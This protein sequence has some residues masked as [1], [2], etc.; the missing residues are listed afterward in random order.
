MTDTPLK[1]DRH[2]IAWTLSDGEERLAAQRC[3]GDSARYAAEFT[4][5]FIRAVDGVT[6][7]W[8][9]SRGPG[10]VD[11]FWK[12]IGPKGRHLATRIYTKTHLPTDEEVNRFFEHCV[13]VRTA[14]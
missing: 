6:V 9:K 8:S 2:C 14:S 4:K 1:G 5:Q 3:G 7:D 11:E 13:A 12:E 10:S